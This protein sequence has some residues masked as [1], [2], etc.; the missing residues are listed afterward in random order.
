MK[1][2]DRSPCRSCTRVKDPGDCENKCCR[3]WNTWFM[4]SW[5]AIHGYYRQ[6]KTKEE[7]NELEKRGH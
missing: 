2:A 7:Q 3:A 4:K 5:N 1:Y 6:C